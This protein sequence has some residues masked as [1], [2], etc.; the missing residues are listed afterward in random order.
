LGEIGIRG[1]RERELL[2]MLVFGF[3]GFLFYFLAGRERP[4]LAVGM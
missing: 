3:V 4:L 1:E 2:P